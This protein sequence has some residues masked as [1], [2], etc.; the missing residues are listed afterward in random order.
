MKLLEEIESKAVS[1]SVEENEHLIHD[2]IVS[3]DSQKKIDDDFELEIQR[4]ISTIKSDCF[5]IA[6]DATEPNDE[7]WKFKP[8]SIVR[9]GEKIFHDGTLWINCH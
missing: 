6:P 4:R 5:M 3:I 7:N 1:L 8:G 2:L 9:C